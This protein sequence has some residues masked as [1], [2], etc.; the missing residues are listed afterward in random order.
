MGEQGFSPFGKVIFHF[1]RHHRINLPGYDA[2]LLKVPELF[3]QD[4]VTDTVK[5]PE[6]LAEAVGAFVAQMPYDNRFV[7]AADNRLW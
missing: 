6:Q 5:E 3:G 1:G 7:F 2:V 4:A